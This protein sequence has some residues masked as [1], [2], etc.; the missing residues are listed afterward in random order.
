MTLFLITLL[1]FLVFSLSLSPAWYHFC[2]HSLPF[3]LCVERDYASCPSLV[4]HYHPSAS[5]HQPVAISH[6]PYSLGEGFHAVSGR[7]LGL[8]N[9]LLLLS[10]LFVV[11]SFLISS[12]AVVRY[13][14][15][16]VVVQY[17]LYFVMME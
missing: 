12:A 4:G 3:N 5:S 10:S 9:S 7:W 11:V 13:F 14:V 6:Q 1:F 15:R 8:S 17:P 2:G 16:R